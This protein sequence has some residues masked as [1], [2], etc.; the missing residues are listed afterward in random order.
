MTIAG[1]IIDGGAVVLGAIN[2]IVY[3]LLA[4]GLVLAYRSSRVI[5]FAHGEVGAFAA[6]VMAIVSFQCTCPTGS[7]WRS[8]SPSG[9]A[10]AQP[11][12]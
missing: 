5:N 3:G 8:R 10:R 1:W 12:R 9:R 7:R 6:A 4:I 2:G 11:S